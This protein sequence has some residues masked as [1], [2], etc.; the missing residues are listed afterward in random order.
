MKKKNLAFLIVLFITISSIISSTSMVAGMSHSSSSTEKFV[1]IDYFEQVMANS[2]NNP[3]LRA[4]T[5][6]GGSPNLV[7]RY[8][9]TWH[10]YP[11]GGGLC[12]SLAYFGDQ[13]CTRCGTI[14]QAD[15][16]YK[17]TTTGCGKYHQ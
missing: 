14:W 11:Q 8:K 3:S 15:T 6:C 9:S 13:Y 5:C 1:T 7:W 12:L 4:I 17:Q 10:I 16:C 2:K